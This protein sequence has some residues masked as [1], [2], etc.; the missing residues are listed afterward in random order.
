MVIVTAGGVHVEPDETLYAVDP[1][2][3]VI[4]ASAFTGISQTLIETATDST[5][6]FQRLIN[7]AEYIGKPR[8]KLSI[9]AGGTKLVWF[10]PGMSIIIR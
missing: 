7:N 9:E 4:D 1:V 6:A 10:K 8:G 3:L 2:K 5:A